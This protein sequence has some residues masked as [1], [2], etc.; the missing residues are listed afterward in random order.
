[1]AIALPGVDVGHGMAHEYEHESHHV[2]SHDDDHDKGTVEHQPEHSH[3]RVSEALRNR[4]DI[5]DFITLAPPL[6][7]AELVP[8]VHAPPPAYRLAFFEDRATGP[9][10]RVRAP[11]VD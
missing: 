8:F 1:M 4:G 3:D 6:E 5:A 10:P 7:F 9:P 2:S 11:P